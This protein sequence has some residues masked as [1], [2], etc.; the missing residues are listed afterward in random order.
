[1]SVAP[2]FV[3][4]SGPHVET[5]NSV[6]ATGTLRTTI[7]DL[8]HAGVSSMQTATAGSFEPALTCHC[9]LVNVDGCVGKEVSQPFAANPLGHTN[10]QQAFHAPDLT[11][12]QAFLE[13]RAGP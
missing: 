12:V 5:L 7:D 13:M 9:G 6:G 11:A 10:M 2:V 1:M 8:K 4:A 3:S